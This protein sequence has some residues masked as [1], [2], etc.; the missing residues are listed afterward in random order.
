MF[1]PAEPALLCETRRPMA[2]ETV[3]T[4]AESGPSAP[5]PK[6]SAG[7]VSII[8]FKYVKAAAFLLLGG[9]TLRIARL[10]R[11]SEPLEIARMLGVDE[12]KEIVQRTAEVIS[13]LS[14]FQ[15]H[16]IAG[17]LVAIGLVFAA[18]GT[19][20]WLR[21][22]WATYFTIT[23]T[24]LGIPP[25]IIEIARRPHSVRRYLLLAVNVAILIYLWRRRNEFR[26]ARPETY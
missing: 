10:P 19:C 2:S 11:G 24:A 9:V 1:P 20:L 5:K 8:V 6:L 4:A 22:P 17:A 21:F 3:G 7:F 16:A 13:A 18:E 23:L 14:P 15:I 12:H 26:L 25:E